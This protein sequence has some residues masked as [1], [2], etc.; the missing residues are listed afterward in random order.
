MIKVTRSGLD[1]EML[2]S[3]VNKRP[4]EAAQQ[5][6]DLEDKVKTLNME[7]DNILRKVSDIYESGDYTRTTG[8]LLRDILI[9]YEE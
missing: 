8:T 1:F 5:I 2:C 6:M 9:G 7:M 4:D 3:V